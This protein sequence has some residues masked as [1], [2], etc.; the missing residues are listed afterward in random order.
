MTCVFC[1]ESAITILMIKNVNYVN[2]LR[3]LVTVYTLK[4]CNLYSEGLKICALIEAT[5]LRAASYLVDT[6]EADKENVLKNV[7]N[8]NNGNTL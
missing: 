1:K 7:F 2:N 6:A 4:C 8:N 5:E 3:K